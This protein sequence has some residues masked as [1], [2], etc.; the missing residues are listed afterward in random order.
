MIFGDSLVAGFGLMREDS[1][2]SQ[3]EKNLLSENYDIKI[4]NAGVSGET[5]AGGLE[6]RLEWTISDSPDALIL[7]LGGNDML[8]GIPTKNIKKKSFSNAKNFKSKKY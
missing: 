2:P 6:T 7:I 3:L 5:T 4:I 8:R 1:F